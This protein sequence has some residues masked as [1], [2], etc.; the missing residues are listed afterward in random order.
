MTFSF[1]TVD[2]AVVWPIVKYHRRQKAYFFKGD[3]YLR[4]DVDLDR[5]DFGYPRR[6]RED[7][8]GLG[9]GVDAALVWPREVDGRQKAYFFSGNEYARWDVK[10]DRLD[11]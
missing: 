2:A 10:E 6:I 11:I 9:A 5:E 3:S 1:E 4:Y 7:W 8:K